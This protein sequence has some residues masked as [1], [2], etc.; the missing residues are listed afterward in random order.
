MRLS[1]TIQVRGGP[2]HRSPVILSITTVIWASGGCDIDLKWA[3]LPVGLDKNNQILDITLK[4][5]TQLDGAS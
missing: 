3:T 1:E 2:P 4:N 5:K